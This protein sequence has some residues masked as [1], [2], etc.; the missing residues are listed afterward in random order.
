V[1]FRFERST[2]WLKAHLKNLGSDEPEQMLNL[3]R[4]S[5]AQNPLRGETVK[6]TIPVILPQQT[7]ML[8][9]LEQSEKGGN[10]F[11]FM[12]EPAPPHH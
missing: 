9:I 2:L 11:G 5:I 7:P 10:S 3:T 4:D 6:L 8:A 12:I 1:Y